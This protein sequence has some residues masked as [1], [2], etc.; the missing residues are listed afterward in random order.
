MQGENINISNA[1]PQQQLAATTALQRL[2]I[3]QH[4]KQ[5]QAQQ[6]KKKLEVGEV[7]LWVGLFDFGWVDEMNYL[8]S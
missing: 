1:T 6:L 5:Q 2:N 4:E 3:A 7:G 8:L